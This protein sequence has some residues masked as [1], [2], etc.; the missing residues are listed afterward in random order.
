MKTIDINS[1]MPGNAGILSNLYNKPF[2]MD[3]NYF[4]SIEG[5]LQGLRVKDIDTQKEVFAMYGIEAKRQGYSHPVKNDTFYYKGRPMNRYSD[6]YASIIAKA[7]E[8]C[9]AQNE[10]FQ[11]AI[12][13][14][15][16]DTLIH[17]IGKDVKADTIW[18]NTE[19]LGTLSF[20]KLKYD[21]FLEKS[22]GSL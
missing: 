2:L 11:M 5:L 13:E 15:R 7:Y 21:V 9:F 18:T 6:R 20:L 12:Y 1:Y 8:A 16:N 14:T 3:G 22:Y 17:T 10:E 4:G 19:F